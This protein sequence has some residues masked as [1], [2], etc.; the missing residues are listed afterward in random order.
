M[1]L[2]IGVPLWL[3]GRDTPKRRYPMLRG[4]VTADVAIVGGGITGAGIAQAFAEAGVKAVLLESKLVG[5]GS[6][7]AS[8]ALVMHETDEGYT[9][10][11]RRYGH[12]EAERLWTLSRSS[13]RDLVATVR[14]LG[15]DCDLTECDAIHF[16]TRHESVADLYSEYQRRRSG[17][18]AATWLEPTALRAETSIDGA[19]ATPAL[20]SCARRHSVARTSLSARPFSVSIPRAV[21]WSSTHARVP[22]LRTA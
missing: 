9:D 4:R 11:E 10:L 7:A 8:T 2:R 18:F 22:S 13:V 3:S 17:G 12:A 21:K 20:V 1:R 19:G 14:R 5:R 6:T 16:T 15:I